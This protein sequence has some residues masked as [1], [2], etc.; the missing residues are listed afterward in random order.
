MHIHYGA[1]LKLFRQREDPPSNQAIGDI[2]GQNSINVLA[3]DRFLERNHNIGKV[4]Q[5][6]ARFTPDVR[7]VYLVFSVN[8]EVQG[9][10]QFMIMRRTGVR[11]GQER[12]SS[13]WSREWVY[14]ENIGGVAV[15]IADTKETVFPYLGL[16][17]GV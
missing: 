14:G 2:V 8:Y 11:E 6:A 1:K 10:F 12:L 17:F 3:D 9:A 15:Q 7:N 4:V 16:G 13:E 5:I